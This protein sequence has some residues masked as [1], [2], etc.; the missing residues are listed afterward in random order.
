M[1][2][3]FARVD[4]SQA[5]I[6]SSQAELSRAGNDLARRQSAAADGSVSGEDVAHAADSVRTTQAALA[7]AQ[8]RHA[9]ALSAVS[10]TSIENNPEVQAAIAAMRRAG[11]MRS[12]MQIAAP[13]TASSP[14]ARFS[15][16]NRWPQG[17]R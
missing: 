11:I 3:A 17:L 1:R 8:S 15:L 13:W 12:H 14:S 9:Q 10:G 6:A 2:A 16:A 4:E 7:L 5:E